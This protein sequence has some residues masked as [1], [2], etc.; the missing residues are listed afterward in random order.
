MRFRKLQPRTVLQAMRQ[1]LRARVAHPVPE[2]LIARWCEAMARERRATSCELIPA[3]AVI[4][5]SRR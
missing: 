4:N 5:R 1:A 3:R 2:D